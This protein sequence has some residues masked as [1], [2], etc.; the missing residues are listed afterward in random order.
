M[1][2][3]VSPQQKIRIVKALQATGEFCAMTGDGVNDAPA[4]KQADIGTAHWQTVVF[5]VLVFCQLVNVLAIRSESESLWRQG[6]FSNKPLLL[7][8]ESEKLLRRRGLIY[9]R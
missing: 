9:R 8:V 6:L 1:Y 3:R 4:L 2:A 7:A 5:T